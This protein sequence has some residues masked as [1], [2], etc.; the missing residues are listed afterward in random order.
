MLDTPLKVNRTFSD[1]TKELGGTLAEN[2]SG[3]YFQYDCIFSG[4]DFTN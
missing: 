3:T 2:K 4:I 1:G